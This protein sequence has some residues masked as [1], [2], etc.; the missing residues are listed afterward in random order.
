MASAAYQAAKK[1]L[2]INSPSKV[3]RS[4]GT[5]V[6]EGFAMGIEMLGGMVRSSA[7]SM[8]DTAINGTREAI[9]SISDAINSDIDAQ[10]TIR[11]VIDLSDVRSGIGTLG[12]MFDITPSVGVMANVGAISSGMNSLQNVASN[13]DVVSAITALG[14]KLSNVAG[15]TYNINGISY[16]D[17]T[18]VSDAIKT[19]VRAAR[20]ERRV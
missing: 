11:P 20:M 19:L 18:A 13:D 10:P 7:V 3:F 8:A 1:E 17:G 5:S 9:L 4:L 15:D 16:D 2:R 12:S 6:P 14:R